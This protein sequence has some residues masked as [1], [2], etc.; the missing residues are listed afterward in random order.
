MR[1]LDDGLPSARAVLQALFPRTGRAYVVGLTGA[2]GAGKSSLTDRLVA[3]HRAAGRTVGV[4][5]VDP[6]SPYTGERSTVTFV[7]DTWYA[8]GSG[9]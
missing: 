4:V 7:E 8:P 9:P 1:D 3:H 5:A 6:T 2:P